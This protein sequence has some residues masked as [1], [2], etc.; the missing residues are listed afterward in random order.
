MTM[1]I[2]VLF[3]L[4]I[5][6]VAGESLTKYL[7]L[8]IDAAYADAPV[9]PEDKF[10]SAIW[11]DLARRRP[12]GEDIGRVERLV[13][14]FSSVGGGWALGVGWLA[15]KVASSWQ[16]ARTINALP[17]SLTENADPEVLRARSFWASRAYVSFM[18]GTGANLAVALAAAGIA[19]WLGWR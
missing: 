16:G 4:V 5:V 1:A 11:R 3:G 7:V 6:L 15:F 10:P 18:V 17:S 2:A 19:R 14:Y 8:R 9:P 12:G 13:F